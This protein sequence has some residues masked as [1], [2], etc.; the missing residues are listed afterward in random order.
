MSETMD[1]AY[2][3][4][5]LAQDFT[6]Y[7]LLK[8][9]FPTILVMTFMGLYT[10]V[11]TIFV[12][13]F[14]NTDALSAMNII[15]PMNNLIVGLGTMLATGGS[16]IV[17]RKMGEREEKRARQEFTLIILVGVMLGVVISALGVIYLKPI[18]FGLGASEKLYPYC[19]DYLFVLL[20]FT[21][22]CI[23]QVL[24]QNLIVTA[25]KPGLG[26]VLALS[27]GIINVILDYVFMVPFDMGIKG[28]AL[29]TGIG[30]SVPSIIGLIFF[31]HSRGTLHF[32]KPIWNFKVIIESCINGSSEMVGQ[33]ATAVTTFL[34]N[35]TMMRIAGEDGV[36]AI[37]IMIYTQFF[38]STL[39]LGFSMGVAP[40]I[41]F[42][43]GS[44]NTQRLKRILKICF[45]FIMVTS[46]LTCLLLFVFASN[47]VAV[48]SPPDTIVY[49]ITQKGFLVFPMSFLFSGFNIF[50]S[51]LFTA[52]SNGKI[53][54]IISFLRTFGFI[55]AGILLLSYLFGMI[56]VWLAVPVAEFITLFI[57]IA[58][59]MKYK[60]SNEI[61]L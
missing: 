40:I 32:S 10:I 38:A 56:G 59:I 16:A 22:A 54:A 49:E 18:I 24:F 17:A 47:L 33:L 57:S 20:L 2:Q 28:A 25:G 41:S 51:A 58:L 13:R 9:A 46:V 50:V 11:D 19:R 45:G 15:C 29:G 37:T 5:A 26:M 60:S 3:R 42:N 44:N 21:P 8:F 39:Y 7:S 36:A 53:S 48:F 55:T 35:I 6:T 61:P 1:N 52:L 27:A 14:V 23:L 31:I 43:F 12:A 4:N 30:Y 34:F